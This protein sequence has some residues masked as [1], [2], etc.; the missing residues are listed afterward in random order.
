MVNNIPDTPDW[1][2]SLGS[3][4]MKPVLRIALALFAV[5]L[6]PLHALAADY[7]P[8]IYVDEAPEYQPVEI[9]SGWYLRGDVGYAFS[10]P[11]KDDSSY[12]ALGV[13]NKKTRMMVIRS[14]IAVMFKKSISCSFWFLR[15]ALR[16]ADL[17]RTTLAF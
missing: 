14:S 17:K 13:F 1:A 10:H 16:S 3:L 15:T 11:F 8:P 12:N 6:A 5:G 9:G 7:D 2:A 4:T